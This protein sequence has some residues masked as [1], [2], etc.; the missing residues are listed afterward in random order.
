MYINFILLNFL[1][2][3]E[4]FLAVAVDAAKIAGEVNLIIIKLCQIDILF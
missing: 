4:E 3:L 1:G 2:S